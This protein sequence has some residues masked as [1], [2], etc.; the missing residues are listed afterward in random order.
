[1]KTKGIEVPR[2][3]NLIQSLLLLQ[4]LISSKLCSSLSRS[5]LRREH[6]GFMSFM[7]LYFISCTAIPYRASTGPEQ[8]FPC[9]VFPHREKPVFNTEF[10]GD[11]NR[12]FS[13][14]NT[15]QEKPCFHHRDGFAV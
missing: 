3:E 12:F 13:V 6:N 4:G 2:V 9:V 5:W 8:G 14:R 11:E 7:K 15:T 10:P 1:M